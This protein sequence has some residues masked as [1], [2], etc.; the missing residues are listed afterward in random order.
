MCGIVGMIAPD[1]T[2]KWRYNTLRRLLLN[3]VHRGRDATGLAFVDPEDN[4]LVVIK[5]GKEA[6]EF[7]ASKAFLSLQDRI[8]PVVIGHNRAASRQHKGAQI[9]S[10][11]DDNVNNHPFVSEHSDICM[12]HNG[13]VD[14]DMW[15]DTAGKPYGI[16]HPPVSSTDSEI[17]LRVV[18]TFAIKQGGDLLNNIENMCFNVAGD[19]TSAFIRKSEPNS[20]WLTRAGRPLYVA[21]VSYNNAFVFA[22]EEQILKNSLRKYNYVYDFF[23]ASGLPKGTIINDIDDKVIFK[24]SMVQ[25]KGRIKK[26]KYGLEFEMRWPGEFATREY[27]WHHKLAEMLEKAEETQAEA[28]GKEL[29]DEEGEEVPYSFINEFSREN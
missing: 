27:K 5:D 20:I 16:L 23:D 22:S 18:E 1:A 9:I 28:E 4:E 10:S 19:Y 25:G 26:F 17:I 15:A 7:V 12:V 2:S 11:A 8:P 3:S 13:F 24:A 6:S 29:E 21:Y 14:D